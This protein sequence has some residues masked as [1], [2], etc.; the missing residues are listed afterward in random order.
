MSEDQRKDYLDN[1]LKITDQV[2]RDAILDFI[3]SDSKSKLSVD[4]DRKELWDLMKSAV[5]ASGGKA[6]TNSATGY[7]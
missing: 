3:R 4:S 7:T 1:K 6:G 2:A 5:G